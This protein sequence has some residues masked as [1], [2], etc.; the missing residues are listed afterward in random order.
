MPNRAPI[1]ADPTGIGTFQELRLGDNLDSTATAVINCSGIGATSVNVTGVTSFPHAFINGQLSNTGLATVSA[2]A[3]FTGIVTFTSSANFSSGS[4]FG[5]VSVGGTFRTTG[6]STVKTYR[7]ANYA[8]EVLYSTATTLNVTHT[9]GYGNIIYNSSPS[10]DVTFNLTIPTTDP[11][12]YGRSLTYV[13]IFNQGSTPYIVNTININGTSKTIN[14]VGGSAPSGD[15]N[16]KDV[17][18]FNFINTNESAS[19]ASDYIV[20]GNLINQGFGT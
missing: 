8:E 9:D 14:W 7:Q 1:V 12:F 13:F 16:K 17:F 20:L 2:A 5:N 19:S 11:L 6:I 15:A 18:T 4:G 3:S 10:G